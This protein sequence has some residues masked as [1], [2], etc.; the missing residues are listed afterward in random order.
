MKIKTTELSGVAL[1]WAV[2]TCEFD[3]GNICIKDIPPGHPY[4]LVFHEGGNP[5]A[6][7]TEFAPSTNWAQ[8]G[9]IVAREWINTLNFGGKWDAF[10]SSGPIAARRVNGP[11]LLVAAM[12]CFVTGKLGDHVEVPEELFHLT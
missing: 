8:G 6:G 2:A 9:P 12:R 7:G 11:T 1:D 5:R 3:A 10:T 4:V